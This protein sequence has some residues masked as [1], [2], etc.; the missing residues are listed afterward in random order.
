MQEEEG[1]SK[2]R[3]A[4]AAEQQDAAGQRRLTIGELH[5]KIRELGLHSLS[6]SVAMLREDRDD[7]TRGEP[8]PNALELL[9]SKAA[10]G[11]RT[12]TG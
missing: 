2:R 12:P 11:R 6:E 8:S 4:R 5:A 1:E 7:P 3:A 9:K 10:S